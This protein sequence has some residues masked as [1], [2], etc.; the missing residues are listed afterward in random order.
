MREQS[1]KRD[2][3]ISIVLIAIWAVA[4]IVILMRGTEIPTSMLLL[5]SAFFVFLLPA[6]HD[7]VIGIEKKIGGASQVTDHPEET[8]HDR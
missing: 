7:L 5:A 2:W 3:R 4:I 8:T 6:M 1:E